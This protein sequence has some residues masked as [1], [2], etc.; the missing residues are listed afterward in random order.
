[1][2]TS[3]RGSR[4]GRLLRLGVSGDG[5]S[6][7]EVA[8]MKELEMELSLL[9]EEN[10]RLKVER[11]RPPDAGRVIERMRHLGAEHGREESAL[12]PN[13]LEAAQTMHECLAI[14]DGLVAAC[15]EVQQAMQGIRGRLA[16]RRARAPTADPRSRRGGRGARRG[17]DRKRSRLTQP[18]AE[19]GLSRA[20]L[21]I[22]RQTGRRGSKG[23]RGSAG[24]PRDSQGRPNDHQGQELQ[25]RDEN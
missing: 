4:M 11:H 19:R 12:D 5:A 23:E 18:C 6:G 8:A 17:A 24:G 25:E 16:G 21:G 15:Q 22:C 14:R 1:M 7:S 13:A 9:R 2:D 20:H 10:A 3:T